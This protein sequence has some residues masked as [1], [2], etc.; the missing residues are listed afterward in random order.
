MK[1]LRKE[2]IIIYNLQKY[3]FTNKD[4]GEVV[5]KTKISYLKEISS[6]SENHYGLRAL[7]TYASGE[8]FETL[9]KFVC[10][11]NVE[12]SLEE[13]DTDTGVRF[14]ISQVENVKIK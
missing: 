4:T 10:R 7:A 11:P 12:A 9:K 13:R 5:V 3:S 1:C 14:V 6:P 8:Y 2:K